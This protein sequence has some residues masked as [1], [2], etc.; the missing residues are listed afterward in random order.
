MLWFNIEKLIA[1]IIAL[2]FIILMA[3]TLN[4]CNSER[5]LTKEYHHQNYCDA[6]QY[7]FQK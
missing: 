2:S 3:V 4:S 7:M 6:C 5:V 1:T